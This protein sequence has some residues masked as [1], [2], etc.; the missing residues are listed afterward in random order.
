ME[1]SLKYISLFKENISR[2]EFEDL[3][4]DLSKF[5]HTENGIMTEI[6]DNLHPNFEYEIEVRIRRVKS[7]K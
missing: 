6:V 5:I 2:N 1:V 3:P 7:T 4:E